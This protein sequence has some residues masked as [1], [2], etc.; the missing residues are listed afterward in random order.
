MADKPKD[1]GTGVYEVAACTPGELS[2]ADLAACLA[3]IR[4]GG[5]VDPE[6]AAAEIPKGRVLVV[7]RSGRDVVGVGAIKRVRR[8]YASGVAGHSGEPFPPDTPELG[9]V[10][11]D[12]NHRGK[13]LAPCIV[14]ALL[15]KHTGG[16]FATTDN[17][18]M[19][20]TLAKA[21]FVQRG[22]EWD[23]QRGRLSLWIKG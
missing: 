20:R 14:A 21:G 22:A 7:V 11:V 5:A 15:S 6:S 16:L 13:G 23:G 19:K 3:I 18:R 8:T 10:A 2:K 4:D 1:G 17:C 9:Y 12:P